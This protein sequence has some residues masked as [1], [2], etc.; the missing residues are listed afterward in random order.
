MGELFL[1]IVGE[2]FLKARH[3]FVIMVEENYLQIVVGF[4]HERKW[5]GKDLGEE[6]AQTYLA[7]ISVQGYH[8]IGDKSQDLRPLED[9]LGGGI[10]ETS[11]EITKHPVF[12]SLYQV[13]VVLTGTKAYL[14][15]CSNVAVKAEKALHHRLRRV[16]KATLDVTL[17]FD[18]NDEVS[19][20]LV[21]DYV[22]A[23]FNNENNCSNSAREPYYEF[24]EP[25][26]GRIDATADGPIRAVLKL[27]ERLTSYVDARSD[28]VFVNNFIHFYNLSQPEE[29]AHPDRERYTAE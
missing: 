28:S 4:K 11:L 23:F 8:N 19:E 17:G 13:S 12:G 1:K 16:N 15:V 29:A 21:S 22:T 25:D 27:R 3:K 18:N 14:E 20:E 2:I 9:H 7:G 5:F 10:V 26:R 24:D 6:E